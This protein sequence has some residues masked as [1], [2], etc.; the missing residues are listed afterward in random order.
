M[1]H[2]VFFKRQ[3]Y[4]ASLERK[5]FVHS[6]YKRG[7]CIITTYNTVGM[8]HIGRPIENAHT[9]G[10]FKEFMEDR[11]NDKVYFVAKGVVF[12]IIRIFCG[13]FEGS[14]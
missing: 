14:L 10:T 12:F 6:N 5:L 7:S 8:I 3:H 4:A 1:S 11:T 2:Q 9:E 13:I